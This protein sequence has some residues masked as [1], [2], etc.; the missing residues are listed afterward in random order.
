MLPRSAPFRKSS[1]SQGY[2]N[3][4]RHRVASTL[5]GRTVDVLTSAHTITHG[6][7]TGVLSEAGVEKLIV[8]GLEY[9]LSQLLVVTPTLPVNAVIH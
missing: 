6:V 7:V 1:S 9:D 2:L 5:V 4:I 3:A 8:G